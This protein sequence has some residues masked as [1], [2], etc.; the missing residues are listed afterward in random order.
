MNCS[1]RRQRL[2]EG[3]EDPSFVLIFSGKAPMRSADEAYEFVVDRNFFYLTG[4]D[5]ENMALLLSKRNGVCHSVLFIEPYDEMLARWVGGRMR[6]EEAKEISAVD[7]VRDIRD[8][9]DHLVNLYARG[10][11]QQASFPVYFD[12]WRQEAE[13][14][15]T[16]GIDYAR[17]LQAKYP[18]IQVKDI[19]PALTS[20]RLVKD[21]KEITAIRKAIH[22]TRLGIEAMMRSIRPNQNEMQ[23]EAVFLFSLMQGGCRDVAFHTIAASGER[24]TTRHSSDTAQTM[25]DG[26]LF[27][28]AL[29]ATESHY[30]ADISRTF[31]VNG[32]FSDRQREI[33]DLVLTVQKKVKD[34][35]RPGVSIR[36]LQKLVIDFYREELPKH[37]LYKDV[38]EYYFHGIGH[39]LGLDTH[40]V[41]GGLGLILQPGHVI[42]DE[43]GLYIRDEGIGIRI[44][45]DLLI[46]EEGSEWLSA[47]IIKEPEAIEAFMKR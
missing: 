38:S 19:F 29:G 46:T 27:L 32:H 20:L 5:R 6:E 16:P 31:P 23:M 15:R 33:Y 4:I 39:H 17:K 2:L 12:L 1:L 10:L 22:R 7:E 42:T 34:A 45:D 36:D 35:A 30:C 41:D 8:L 44:E 21:E 14:D 40:D 9:D 24:A 11:R 28:C 43:P 26:E 13:Q 37:G 3:L 25:R 18:Q 47:E